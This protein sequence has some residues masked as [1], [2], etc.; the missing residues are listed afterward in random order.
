MIHRGKRDILGVGIS[1]VDY[2][3]ATDQVI[4]AAQARQPLAVS[5]LAVHGVMTGVLDPEHRYRLNRFG[6][7]VPDGQPVRWALRWIHGEV[8]PDRVTG[9]Q[10]TIAIFGRAAELGLSVFLFG[11]RAEILDA[12][13]MRLASD[14]PS[15]RIAGAEPSAFRQLTESESRELD[16]RIRAS[17]ADIVLVGL[18][19]PRQ[20]VF[21]YE[22]AGALGRPTIAVGAAYDYYAGRL[23]RAPQWIQSAGLE[24]AVRLA[25]E[26]RRLWKRYLLLNPLYLTLLA[27]QKLGLLRPEAERAPSRELRYG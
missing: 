25:Q 10:L 20:E 15:L 18:G 26:P 19:C 17:G 2:E 14:F 7:V 1:V 12:M 9:P 16:E 6:L 22:H 23:S 27:R 8:L 13:R 3:G 24:W 11:S 21:A 5:A 4:E